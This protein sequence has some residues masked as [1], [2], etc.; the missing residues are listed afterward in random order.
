MASLIYKCDCGY[1]SEVI[2][3]EKDSPFS[4]IEIWFFNNFACKKEKVEGKGFLTFDSAVNIAEA[5]CPKCSVKLSS[6]NINR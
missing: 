4:S 5:R 1:S 3:L 6:Q 2:N